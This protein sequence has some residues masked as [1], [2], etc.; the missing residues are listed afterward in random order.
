[1]IFR[2]KRSLWQS[3]SLRGGSREAFTH[4]VVAPC[5]FQRSRVNTSASCRNTIAFRGIN[6]LQLCTPETI[7]PIRQR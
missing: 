7:E 6:C 2:L 3:M 5:A 4:P 1:M